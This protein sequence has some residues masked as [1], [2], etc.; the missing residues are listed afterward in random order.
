MLAHRALALGLLSGMTL[1][2][3]ATGVALAAPGDL[4]SSFG[5]PAGRA[6]IDFGDDDRS[7]ALARQPDGKLVVA[8][9][10]DGP[11][12]QNFVLARLGPDG[13]L[14]ASFGTAGKALVD[15]GG[16]D[17]AS[18]VALQ[19]DGKIVVVGGHV[20][21][22]NAGD[23]AVARLNPDGSPDGTFGQAG[24]RLVDFGGADS[25]QSVAVL[26][27]GKIL[28]GGWSFANGYTFALT[29]LDATGTP[30]PTFGQG[31]KAVV[32][33]GGVD[34][35]QAL[36]LQQDGKIVMVGF[37]QVNN[38]TNFA[39]ARLD[40]GGVLDPT[41]GQAGKATIDFGGASEEG[42]G[43]ALQADGKIVVTG[44][45]RGN[46]VVARLDAK[47]SLDDSFAGDGKS[48][49][50][51]GGD[52]D[53]GD[54]VAV[55]PDGKLV[56]AGYNQDV[57][58]FGIGRLQPNGLLDTTFGIDGKVSV[59]FGGSL[60]AAQAILL[61]P[62][63]KIVAAGYSR[64]AQKDDFAVARLLGDPGGAAGG[65]GGPG[66]GGP[67]AGPPRCAG[68][69]ATIV[70]TRAADR[71]SGTRRRD[72]IVSLG[73]KDTIRALGGSDIVCAGSGNDRVL[74]GAGSD[75]VLGG[76]GRDRLSGESGN[77]RLAGESGKDQLLGQS[78]RDRLAGGS[79]KDQLI[80]G[81]GRD[82]LLGG[83]GR[84]AQRQ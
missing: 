21:A 2:A 48:A 54:A 22:P 43:I 60:D 47:G 62:D 34:L 81:A 29:R 6:R 10:S 55:Q 45:S 38:N 1:W 41:F 31:G 53:D 36:A 30:D 19:P 64:L 27:D 8:G 82:R 52:F 11:G 40:G 78:G 12:S 51:F 68:K 37:S 79:G 84:D 15:F 25:A 32:D 28:V 57:G 49:I 77:D 20:P 3:G 72:V 67:G 39:I 35:G 73:G 69:R 44:T 33:F 50:D 58:E 42:R 16:N 63:G 26:P 13:S 70:G 17:G 74:A 66:P 83:P 80:G 7:Q 4:D 61:Q 59:S 5:D 65:P 76:G 56:I 75:R 23:F 46:A 9:V 24:K 14:D 71:L 18:G